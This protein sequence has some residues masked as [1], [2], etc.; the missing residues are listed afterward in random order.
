MLVGTA[1]IVVI[2]RKNKM[3]KNLTEEQL[4]EYQQKEQLVLAFLSDLKARMQT[5]K[6]NINLLLN[7]NIG[8]TN[9]NH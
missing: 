3:E 1:T 8:D 4:Q 6:N 2:V 9:E 5:T 7:D